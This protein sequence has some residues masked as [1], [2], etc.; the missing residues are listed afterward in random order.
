MPRAVADIAPQRNVGCRG[1]GN[2]LSTSALAKQQPATYMSYMTCRSHPTRLLVSVRSAEEADSALA[3]GADFIDIKEPK[4]GALGRADDAVI[5]A[6]VRE[7]AGRK[8]ISAALGELR[9]QPLLPGGFAGLLKIGLAGCPDLSKLGVQRALRGLAH[10]L[11]ARR[12]SELVLVAYADWQPAASPPPIE[13]LNYAATNGYSTFMIDT[14][15]KDGRTLLDSL[16]LA[17][18][19]QMRDACRAAGMRL[20]LAGS[21]GAA[22]IHRLLP[23]EPDVIAV[24]GAACDGGLRGATIDRDAVGR[25]AR[26]VQGS[27]RKLT[28]TISVPDSAFASFGNHLSTMPRAANSSQ[29]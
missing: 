28:S 17:N 4:R 23:I 1:H 16:P 24:R 18:L 22:E 25:L 29:V 13:V 19:R 26:L 2:V 27:S 5:A 8:P 11:R 20:A 15:S 7:V 12:D 21:L 6:I 14:W 9:E 10:G 3:G